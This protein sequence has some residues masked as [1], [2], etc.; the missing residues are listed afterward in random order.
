MKPLL[1]SEQLAC[2]LR[3]K[4]RPPGPPHWW[5]WGISGS[6]AKSYAIGSLNYLVKA[7]PT[8]RRRGW[9]LKR[10]CNLP[11]LQSL[12]M[13]MVCNPR[14]CRSSPHGSNHD[15]ACPIVFGG[16]ER[17]STSWWEHIAEESSWQPR[18]KG[19]GGRVGGGVPKHLSRTL[20]M[21]SLGAASLKS[22][23]HS[24]VPCGGEPSGRISRFN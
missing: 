3:P 18:S 4:H 7:F 22:C 23:Y 14:L 20:S 1:Q 10:L 12:L 8:Y 19:R 11:S 2:E 13:D 17:G 15:L 21:I 6:K 9:R 5:C 16:P 24:M